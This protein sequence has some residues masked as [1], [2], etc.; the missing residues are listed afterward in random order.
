MKLQ[1]IINEL[2]FLRRGGYHGEFVKY[3]PFTGVVNDKKVKARV[4]AA[5]TYRWDQD[6]GITIRSYDA[7]QIEPK[8]DDVIP[9]L[10]WNPAMHAILK[11]IED[12][13]MDEAAMQHFQNTNNTG[14]KAAKAFARP[15]KRQNT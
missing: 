8:D 4:L 1:Q 14:P 2:D 12:G 6:A 9:Q 5:I 10:L 13:S 11:K 15:R 3:I 7:L